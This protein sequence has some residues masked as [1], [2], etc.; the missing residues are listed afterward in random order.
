MITNAFISLS[1]A[2]LQSN[3]AAGSPH[4]YLTSKVYKWRKSRL[5]SQ[6]RLLPDGLHPGP[7]FLKTGLMLY[8][9]FGVRLY[10]YISLTELR[11]EP[12][13]KLLSMNIRSIFPKINVLRADVF[14]LNLDVLSFCETWLRETVPNSID[15]DGYKLAQADRAIP[16]FGGIPKKGGGLCIY[17]KDHFV[18]TVIKESTY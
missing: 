15:I 16:V 11:D 3:I 5:R 9:T 4:F 17:Y 7:L 14:G 1:S 13:F 12:G 2:I 10:I 6:Y 18:S 8:P